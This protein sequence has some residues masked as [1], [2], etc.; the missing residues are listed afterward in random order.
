MRAA[1]LEDHAAIAR[2]ERAA[3]EMFRGTAMDP[4]A[5]DEPPAP[6]DLE[7]FVARG[8]AWL[9][10]VAGT[11]RAYLLVEELDDAAHVEQVSVDPEVAGR[12]IGARLL[13]VAADWALARGLARLTLTT[14]VEIPW[15]APHYRR[16]GFVDLPPH[17]HGPQLGVRLREEA[18]HGLDRWPRTTMMRPVGTLSA[19]RTDRGR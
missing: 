9:V 16:L 19:S 14:F 11:A 5:D 15:N 4:I 2:I 18:A 13:D 8:G 17:R 3:G 1:G 6:R 12:R 7:R 10:E